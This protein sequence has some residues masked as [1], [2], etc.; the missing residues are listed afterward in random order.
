MRC[1]GVEREALGD[2]RRRH[3]ALHV[4]FVGQNENR[5]V[6]QVLKKKKRERENMPDVTHGALVKGQER[7][8]TCPDVTLLNEEQNVKWNNVYVNVL[9]HEI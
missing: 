9:T 2:L 6:L 7:K 5:S 1:D 3:G 8:K 4:L